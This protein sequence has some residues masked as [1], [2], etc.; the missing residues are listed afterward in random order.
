MDLSE[1][2]VIARNMEEAIKKATDKFGQGEYELI[3]D[4][5][6]LDTWFSSGIY[7]FS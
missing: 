6:V 7:P 4:E 5:D 3:Q 1:E 2:W